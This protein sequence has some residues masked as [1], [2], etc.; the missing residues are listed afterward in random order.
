MKSYTLLMV[1]LVEKATSN[2]RQERKWKEERLLRKR[3]GG[4]GDHS[5]SGGKE[6]R[7]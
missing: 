3:V 1:I 7:V 6:G 5:E 2:K 4:W